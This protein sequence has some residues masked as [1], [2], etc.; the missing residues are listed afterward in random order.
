MSGK[1]AVALLA[2][3][4]LPGLIA[5]VQLRALYP[6]PPP[7]FYS[8]A[9]QLPPW[10]CW[11]PATVA[12]EMLL[13]ERPGPRRLLA[14]A[15]IILA[16]AVAHAGVQYLTSRLFTDQP[17]AKTRP[18]FGTAVLLQKFVLLDGLAAVCTLAWARGRSAEKRLKAQQLAAS[19]LEAALSRAQL[20]ALRG[21]LQPHFLF[22]SLNAIRVLLR[23]DRAAEGEQLIGQLSEL[24]RLV[25]QHGE[26]A[27]V[28]LREE[29]AFVE[30]YLQIQRARFP[31][32]LSV[33]LDVPTELLDAPV[34]SL[35]L[36]PIVENALEHGVLPK[37]EPS[38]VRLS[39]RRDGSAL[40]LEVTDDGIGPPTQVEEGMGLRNVRERLAHL[41]PGGHTLELTRAPSGGA[42][43]RVR[44]PLGSE[45]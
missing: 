21:R 15:G 23:Q 10:W 13:V 37:I 7:L 20:E 4:S 39:A 33:E 14:L 28:P 27:V 17:I 6:P 18:I 45:G 40:L 44:L 36:Q 29:I 11:I 22:N 38:L 16:A 32:R 31:D 42:I 25:L 5:A 43:C 35:L 26:R 24:L 30:H 1:R 34:P 3:W 9:W 12:I 41:Y 2:I 8:L 19:R